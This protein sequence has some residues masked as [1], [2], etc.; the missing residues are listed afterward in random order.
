MNRNLSDIANKIND[1]KRMVGIDFGSF[2]SRDTFI[3]AE[4]EHVNRF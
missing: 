1:N 4:S 3:Y 2:D